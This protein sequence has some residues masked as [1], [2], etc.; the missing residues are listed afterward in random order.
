MEVAVVADAINMIEFVQGLSVRKR[1]RACI[2][3]TYDYSGQK[4]W[5]AKLARQADTEHV[6]LLDLFSKD[7]ELSKRLRDYSVAKLFSLLRK[8]E[9]NEVLIISGIEFLKASWSG[10]P[11]ASEQFACQVETWQDDPALVFVIQYDKAIAE[12]PFRRFGQFT[13]VVD[14]RDTIAL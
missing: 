10:L 1:G 14:Q 8:R 12:R 9:N 4:K 11:N 5:A 3:M 13:F 7:R 2:V 6:N